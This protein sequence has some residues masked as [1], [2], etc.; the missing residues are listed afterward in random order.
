[1]AE[2]LLL[3]LARFQVSISSRRSLASGRVAAFGCI[4]E[5]Y[6]EMPGAHPVLIFQR[7]ALKALETTLCEHTNHARMQP[8]SVCRCDGNAAAMHA[9]LEAEFMIVLRDPGAR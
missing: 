5:R 4:G 1:M 2:W 6:Y 7:S 9:C 8:R 3:G